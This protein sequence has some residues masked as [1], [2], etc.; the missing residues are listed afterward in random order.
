MDPDQLKAWRKSE[1]NRLIEAREALGAAERD[2]FRHRIDAH[3]Q[4]AFPGLAAAKLAFCW[5]I[6]GEY[7][8]RHLVRTLRERGALTALPVVVAPRQPLE[9]RE[10]HPGVRLASGPLGIPY[11]ADS[12]AVVP[13]AVLL[14]MNGWDEAGYRLGYGGGFF[15]RTLAALAK[16]PAVIGI[17]YELARMQTIH[18]QNWDIP[19]DWVV[20]ERG[21][22]RRDPGRDG[23]KLAFLGEPPAGEPSAL[24]SPVC[25]AN[26]IA[27]GYFGEDQPRNKR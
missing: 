25:Y 2:R 7:D 23:D 27:P 24:A 15:D 10:W 13:D 19:V 5:P 16:K 4:R 17:S 20:T 8:A 26:E 3:L 12:A 11:P 14:P 1:R 22:Y 21:V 6:R 18:P 9:F